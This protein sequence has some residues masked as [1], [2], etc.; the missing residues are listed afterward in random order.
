MKTS[1][2]FVHPSAHAETL[3]T[4]PVRPWHS[5]PLGA[6]RRPECCAVGVLV[7]LLTGGPCSVATAQSIAED[8]II[9]KAFPFGE[10][11]E[12][13]IDYFV[14]P[15][16]PSVVIGDGRGGL[17]LY[18]SKTNSLQWPWVRS[19]ITPNGG[20]YER[21][22]SIKFPGDAYPNIVAS[23]G[24]KIVWFENPFCSDAPVRATHRHAAA[25]LHDTCTSARCAP[26]VAER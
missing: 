2:D 20:A 9:D 10:P 23:I 16:L 22:R 8:I 19:T 12:K 26:V 3:P 14:S 15:A 24:N 18:R 21:A 1:C 5:E 17:Y 13:A 11:L 25:H 4:L 6:S 7:L